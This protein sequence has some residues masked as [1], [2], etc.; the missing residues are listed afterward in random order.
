MAR[1]R[2]ARFC[3]FDSFDRITCILGTAV[4]EAKVVTS[5]MREGV[6]LP[7]EGVEVRLNPGEQVVAGL[8][9]P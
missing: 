5:K 7:V 6:A 3:L 2:Q 4:R 9:N 1:R 8:E